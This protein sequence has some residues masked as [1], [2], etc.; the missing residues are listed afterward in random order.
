MDTDAE[1]ATKL[2]Q[3]R[4]SWNRMNESRILYFSDFG[5]IFGF[6]LGISMIS[7]FTCFQWPYKSIARTI[8]Y[9]GSVSISSFHKKCTLQSLQLRQTNSKVPT[10][11]K[12]TKTA[13]SSTSDL[14]RPSDLYTYL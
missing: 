5:G 1:V 7:F 2:K 14:F 8:T 10:E 4:I 9:K 3:Y 6:S 11:M 12:R 13:S